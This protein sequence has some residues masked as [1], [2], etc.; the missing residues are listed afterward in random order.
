MI[1][2]YGTHGSMQRIIKR[3]IHK[4]YKIWVLVAEAYGYVVQFK[5]YQGGKKGEQV[6]YSTKWGSGENVALRLMECLTPTFNF[7][8]FMDNYFTSFCLLIRLGDINIQ[9]TGVLNENSLRKSPIIGYKQLQKKER[10][11]FVQ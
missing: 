7:D 5:P 9:A 1:P 2:C 4:E 3:S 10:G 6:S 11:H 8:I